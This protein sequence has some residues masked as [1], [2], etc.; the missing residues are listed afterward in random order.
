METLINPVNTPLKTTL[1]VIYI[2]KDKETDISQDVSADLL[3]VSY[4]DGITDEADKVSIT[5]KDETGKWAGFW[6]PTRGDKVVITISTPDRGEISTQEMIIDELSTSGRPRVFNFSAV[7]IPLDGTVR[8]TNK[9]RTFEKTTLKVIANKIAQDNNLQ[10]MWD[11]QEAV[12]YDRI[13]QQQESD[14]AFLKK[15][16]NEAGLTVKVTASTLIIFDQSMYEKNNAV[17]SIVESVSPIL[18]WS[19]SAQQSQRYKGVTIK[20]RNPE[21]KTIKANA[22]TKPVDDKQAILDSYI[23]GYQPAKGAKVKRGNTSTAPEYINYTYEDPSVDDSGQVYILKKRCTNL[24]DAERLA[25]AKLRKLNLRQ[26]TG[27]L[28]LIGDPILCAGSVFTLSGFGSFDGNFI[29]ET[30]T[31]TVDSSGYKTSITVRRVNDNY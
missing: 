17:A 9:T 13:D 5:L 15:L 1:K 30:A 26:L 23:N 7:S 21:K 29:I 19:F 10:L 24:A 4:T 6:T 31:H 18:S 22:A 27:N 16:A 2:T 3:S 11:C 25:K 12:N 14:L 8:R 28:T 20:W